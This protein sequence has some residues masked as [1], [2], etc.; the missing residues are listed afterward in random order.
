MTK[1]LSK[2]KASGVAGVLEIH[3]QILGWCMIAGRKYTP[4]LVPATMC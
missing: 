2:R 4:R 1:S 3:V